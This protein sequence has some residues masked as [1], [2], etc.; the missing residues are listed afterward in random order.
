MKIKLIFLLSLFLLN[1]YHNIFTMEK[2]YLEQKLL[3]VV[4]DGEVARIEELLTINE[5]ITNKNIL[6]KALQIAFASSL[7]KRNFG[8]KELE[9]IT[10]LLIDAGANPHIKNEKNETCR[11]YIEKLIQ[12]KKINV[13]RAQTILDYLSNYKEPIEII[14]E[15]VEMSKKDTT[16]HDICKIINQEDIDPEMAKNLLQNL[17]QEGH[18]PNA[19]DEFGNTPL[20][21]FENPYKYADIIQYFVLQG[22]NPFIKNKDDWSAYSYCSDIYSDVIPHWQNLN[23]E[24]PNLEHIN[25]PLGAWQRDASNNKPEGIRERYRFILYG[26][27]NQDDIFEY[28]NSEGRILV[29]TIHG[30]GFSAIEDSGPLNR[31][32]HDCTTSGFTGIMKF[33]R[34]YLLKYNKQNPKNK[35]RIVHLVSF[36]WNGKLS[37]TFSRKPAAEQ[38]AEYIEGWHYKYSPLAIVAHSHGCT[39]ASLL[40]YLLSIPKINDSIYKKREK[41]EIFLYKARVDSL[42]YLNPPCRNIEFEKS[43]D[44]LD[45]NDKIGLQNFLSKIKAITVPIMSTV[46]LLEYGYK[47]IR[48]IMTNKPINYDE[49]FVFK[50]KSD[51]TAKAGSFTIPQLALLLGSGATGFMSTKT[52]FD[53][54]KNLVCQVKDSENKKQLA[55]CLGGAVLSTYTLGKAYY[56]IKNTW[57]NGNCFTD[58]R[59]VNDE[60]IDEKSQKKYK[61][62]GPKIHCETLINL[63]D[64]GH[65]NLAVLEHFPTIW[66][67][68]KTSYGLHASGSGSFIANLNCQINRDSN[69]LYNMQCYIDPE[70]DLIMNKIQGNPRFQHMYWRM[71]LKELA[72]DQTSIIE[73]EQKI[74]NHNKQ[75]HEELKLMLQ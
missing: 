53:S 71:K 49:C 44:Q 38:L 72:K 15:S 60:T 70:G 24:F 6:N 47:L 41:E 42:V 10:T 25:D 74:S 30:T 36:E 59:P 14:E 63:K 22:A 3:E 29:L 18:D 45:D 2:D 61:I 62:E 32:Y 11:E 1:T 19:K 48:K 35:K 52:S 5:L 67:F 21:Y 8:I 31:N 37:D 58:I 39:I 27:E 34:E 20:H 64:A 9:K 50:S 7:R 43:M 54:I 55:L 68:I 17:I 28:D 57:S 4:E 65:S 51:W 75:Q 26:K 12:K 56:N 69:P 40:T 46:D 33:A 73:K 16:L 13:N 23:Q 66:N